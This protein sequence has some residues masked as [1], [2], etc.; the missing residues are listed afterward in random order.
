MPRRCLPVRT[1]GAEIEEQIGH[2]FGVGEQ[3]Q[4]VLKRVR[5]RDV[6][7][8]DL[9]LALPCPGSGEIRAVVESRADYPVARP[10]FFR[11]Q[12]AHRDEPLS[13]DRKRGPGDMQVMQGKNEPRSCVVFPEGGYVLRQEP[14]SQVEAI[15]EVE[16]GHFFDQAYASFEEESILL[17]PLDGS[18][19]CSFLSRSAILSADSRTPVM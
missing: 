5:S 12:T 18:A 10:Q 16:V 2:S 13:P 4:E 15:G 6:R 11:Q 19:A 7:N 9:V 14:V 8:R 17:L 1:T 3:A